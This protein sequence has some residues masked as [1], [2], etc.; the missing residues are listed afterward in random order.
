VK[1]ISESY[2]EFTA[3][4]FGKDSPMPPKMQK[5]TFNEC[6]VETLSEEC[7]YD[8]I[9]SVHQQFEEMILTHKESHDPEPLKVTKSTVKHV[10]ESCGIGA[11]KVESLG[12][13]MDENFGESAELTPKNIVSVNKFEISTPSVTVKVDPEH[14]D[15]VTTDI[16]NGVQYILIRATDG[17]EVNGIKINTDDSE[18]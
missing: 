13:A 5:A 2:P 11:D 18:K 4:I 12:K 7:S 14:K 8:V 17:V 10:L 1:S 3:N 6:L 15:L 16:I 9:R